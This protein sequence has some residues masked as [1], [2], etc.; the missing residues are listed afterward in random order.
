MKANKQW[1]IGIVVSV[2][3]LLL[4]CAVSPAETYYVSLKGDDTNKG[5]TEQAA[6]RTIKKGVSVLKAGDTLIIKSGDYG[7]ER[8]VLKN[9]GRKDAP[10]LIKAEKPGEAVL[11]GNRS[12]VGLTMIDKSYVVVEGLKF[13]RYGVG[14]V[15]KHRSSYVTVRQCIF[16]N[17]ENAGIVLN[18]GGLRDPKLCHHHLFTRNQFLDPLP[19]TQDYGLRMYFSS[20]VEVVNN[21]FHGFHHQACSFKS[22]MTDSRVANNVFEGFHFSAI[23]LGQNSDN[24]RIKQS[25]RSYRLIAEGN[26]FRPSPPYRA[27]SAIVVNNVTNAIVRNNFIDSTYGEDQK[28]PGRR[29]LPGAGIHLTRLSRGTKIYGNVLVNI[30]APKP[31]FMIRSD[32]EIYNNTVVGC[33]RVLDVAVGAKAVVRNNIFYKNA[34]QVG[35]AEPLQPFY[36]KYYGY[37]MN[38]KGVM[39]K[40]PPA[41]KSAKSVFDSN[42]W[43]PDWKGKSP[44]GISAEPLF[45]GPIKPLVIKK[46]SAKYVPNFKRMKAYR[47]TK[48]SPCIDKG[49]KTDL[50]FVGKA[51]D[52]G[53]FEFGKKAPK[54]TTKT[55]SR[56]MKGVQVKCIECGK[57]WEIEPKDAMSVTGGMEKDG[58]LVGGDCPTCGKKKSVFLMNQCPNCRKYYLSKRITDPDA[59]VEGG[60]KEICPHCGT[61][62]YKWYKA[63]RR[64]R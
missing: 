56:L 2:G 27:K 6:F 25:S 40:L 43:F 33:S 32:C 13:T 12:G 55:K 19:N 46:A 28:G 53:A 26:I 39:V 57:E 16:L 22:I 44:N 34:H 36:N 63:H 62:L 58:T 17:N 14:L 11:K 59:F 1:L 47:L 21:Y 42:L 50:P 31:A 24:K 54:K 5:M 23:Q 38:D 9:S 4:G 15:I 30:K 7:A 60:S 41:D 52:I 20:N 64:R 8:A 10:I 45:V 51:A 37:V 48:S 49:V 18:D 29:F 3:V 35:V 61:D